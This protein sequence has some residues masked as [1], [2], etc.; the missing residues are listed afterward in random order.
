MNAQITKLLKDYDLKV[1]PQRMCIVEELMHNGHL[2]IEELYEKIREKFPSLSLATVYKNI[3]AMMDKEFI[4]EVKIPNLKSKFELSKEDHAHIICKYCG[5]VEDINVNSMDIIKE[6]ESKS[7]YQIDHT[8]L[9]F[10][11][12][13]PTCAL[14]K[15]GEN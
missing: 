9:I 13:C 4:K 12:I 3:H 8:E 6:V 2:S 11:G 15:N 1:T 5:K 10:S 7:S 14:H